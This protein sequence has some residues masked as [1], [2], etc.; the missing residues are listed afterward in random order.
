MS[1][2]GTASDNATVTQVTWSNSRGG[3]GTAIGTTSWNAASISLQDGSNTLTVTAR[4]AAGNSATDVLTVTYNAPDTTAPVVAIA[5]PTS[6]SHFSA[7]TAT[8]M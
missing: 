1:L 3:N 4:D 7:T 6:A 5:L 2:G 8:A